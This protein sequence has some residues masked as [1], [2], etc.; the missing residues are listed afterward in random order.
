MGKRRAFTLIELLVVIAIIAL[1]MAI[2]MPALAKV[3]KQASAVAC[4]ANLKQWGLC[5]SMYTDSWDGYYPMGTVSGQRADRSW[6]YI[7]QPYYR[8]GKLRLC[9]MATKPMPAANSTMPGYRPP[10]TFEALGPLWGPFNKAWRNYSDN[11]PEPTFPFVVLGEYV[12]Y[13][14][15]D[16]VR[17]DPRAPEDDPTRY[18][19]RVRSADVK[20]MDKI[21]L[22]LDGKQHYVGEPSENSA[23]PAFK[24]EP[25]G[26]GSMGAFC[27]DRHDYAINGVF[28]DG[29]VREINLKC[30]W[31]LKWHMQWDSCGPWT[32]CG[33]A[34]AAAWANAAPWMSRIPQ[35]ELE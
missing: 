34:D 24:D 23:P 26:F 1:L 11:W 28:C 9:P 19:K 21:P 16:W 18:Y 32:I 30:L 12:S 8:D 33:D 25:A 13:L 3:K 14:Q 31:T 15:N 29:S 10:T 17:N 2:L 20:D 5:Y 6:L 27:I 22:M 35:C 7:L 4:Q